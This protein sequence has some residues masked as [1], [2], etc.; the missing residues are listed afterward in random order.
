MMA[1]LLALSP[2][3][4]KVLGLYLMSMFFLQSKGE[5]VAVKLPVVFVSVCLAICLRPVMDP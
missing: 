5:V 3:N 2:H 1:W 4:K